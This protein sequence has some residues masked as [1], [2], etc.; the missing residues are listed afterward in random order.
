[1]IVTV[2]WSQNAEIPFPLLIT[3]IFEPGFTI[4]VFFFSEIFGYCRTPDENS[5]TC[6]NLRECG[7]LFELLQS[8]EVTEQDRRFLQASQC[9]YRNGQVLVSTP[10]KS[11]GAKID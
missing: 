7:Y 4:Y 10:L 6:I 1:M 11:C 2:G 5:G 8:E 9:G 3:T